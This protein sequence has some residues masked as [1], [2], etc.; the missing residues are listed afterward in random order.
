M[1]EV[2]CR[3]PDPAP[4]DDA[5]TEQVRDD[6]GLRLPSHQVRIL[7]PLHLELEGP[8]GEI[9]PVFLDDLRSQCMDDACQD[10]RGVFVE[11]TAQLTEIRDVPLLLSEL[12]W[13]VALRLQAPE[14]HQELGGDLVIGLAMPAERG[15]RMIRPA[16]LTAMEF[17]AQDAFS[18]AKKPEPTLAATQ[19][20]QVWRLTA[21]RRAADALLTERAWEGDY[22]LAVQ[23]N[24][25]L[26][27]GSPE[28][29]MALRTA[30]S[31]SQTILR[32]G[33]DGWSATRD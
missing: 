11:R 26:V 30:E 31:W 16:E 20:G 8:E 12:R 13:T 6:L 15:A 24:E 28:P 27:A 22:A 7:K 21:E 17:S 33:P 5:L 18:I 19:D 4:T 25:L 3:G 1:S 29:L 23:P 32:R 2:P 9:L 14:L 10:A